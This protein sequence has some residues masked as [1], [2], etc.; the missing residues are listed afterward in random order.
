MS[1]KVEYANGTKMWYVKNMLHRE[2]GPAVEN[3]NGIKLWYL[4]GRLVGY[5]F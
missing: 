1:G 5:G 4:N 2:D 3:A